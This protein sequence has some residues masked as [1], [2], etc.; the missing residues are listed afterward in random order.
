MEVHLIVY[1][2]KMLLRILEE[3]QTYKAKSISDKK[4]S[5]D[6]LMRMYMMQIIDSL[7]YKLETLTIFFEIKNNN[8]RQIYL[9]SYFFDI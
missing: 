2:F 5:Q 3:Q 8:F 4:K 6:K 7:E 9:K 1:I